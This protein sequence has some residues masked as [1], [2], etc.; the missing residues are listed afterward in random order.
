MLFFVRSPIGRWIALTIVLPVIAA[1]LNRLGRT[2]ERR[3]G[4][5]TRISKFLLS[6]S[7]I[8]KRRKG[9]LEDPEVSDR[10]ALSAEPPSHERPSGVA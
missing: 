10:A 7:R 6:T 8:A 2:L 1:L 9:A 4:H 5:P 3:K